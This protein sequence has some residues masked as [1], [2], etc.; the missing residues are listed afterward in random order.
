V[1][2]INNLN[3]NCNN[4]SESRNTFINKNK[5]NKNN[6]IDTGLYGKYPHKYK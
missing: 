6:T 1:K 3:E 4:L 5:K 2:Q